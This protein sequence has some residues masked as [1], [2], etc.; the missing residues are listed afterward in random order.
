MPVLR[1][2]V[3]LMTTVVTVAAHAQ[4][5]THG[6]I[7]SPLGK[8]DIVNG[9]PT[10]ATVKKHYDS[11]DFQRTVQ[12]YLWPLPYVAIGQWQDERRDFGATRPGA[13]TAPPDIEAVK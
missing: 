4:L 7:E 10:D 5:P 13:S 2:S 11:L 1:A 6:S 9:Y 3:T 12:A 8:L